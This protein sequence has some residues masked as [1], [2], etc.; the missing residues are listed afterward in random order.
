MAR[1][2]A[3]T[4]RLILRTEQPGDQQVWLAHM[5]TPEVRA[6]LGGPRP[7]DAIADNFA[8]I[9]A[10]WETKGISL[11]MIERKADGL[12]LG[13]CGLGVIDSPEAPDELAGQWEIGWI[14]RRDCWRKGYAQE[15]ARAMLARAF[16]S[17]DLP[18]V[19]AQTSLSNPP[20]WG[21]MEKLG[22]RRRADLDYGDSRYPAADNPTIIYEMRRADWTALSEDKS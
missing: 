20:S 17:W 8:R 7:A 3:E 1:M 10:D 12:L 14:I 21:L 5:N 2:I 11:A 6:C 4:E 13:D 19:F 16:E 15:A 9:A 18:A 22:M